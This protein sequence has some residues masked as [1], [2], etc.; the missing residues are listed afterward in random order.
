MKCETEL[1]STSANLAVSSKSFVKIFENFGRSCLQII[2][3][4]IAPETTNDVSL[5]AIATQRINVRLRNYYL[6]RSN[7]TKK[8]RSLEQSGTKWFQDST[9]D[10]LI[11][12]MSD[13]L[14]ECDS[15]KWYRLFFFL[16]FAWFCFSFLAWHGMA[17]YCNECQFR[18]NVFIQR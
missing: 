4:Q 13:F 10:V 5:F 3:S 8:N 17:C 9:D 2:S 11:A 16:C 1:I 14:N 15:R 6:N 7:W 12:F 18:Q